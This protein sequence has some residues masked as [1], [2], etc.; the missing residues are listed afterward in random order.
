MK[1]TPN[2]RRLQAAFFLCAATFAFAASHDKSASAHDSMLYTPDKMAWKDGPGSF[3]KGAQFVVL[4]GDPAKEGPFV[5]RIKLPDGFH[6]RPHTHPKVERVTVIS[7][8]FLLAMG[9]KL[10]RASATPL[11]AGS[12]GFWPAG[13][14]HTAWAQGET[15]VQVHGIGPWTITYV[16]P[17]DD[18]RTRK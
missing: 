18:P 17:A 14:V 16:N 7:G 6:I 5:M 15:I 12:Y 2:L 9:D 10:A 11:R 13:M 3:E 8:T 4:E 1:N